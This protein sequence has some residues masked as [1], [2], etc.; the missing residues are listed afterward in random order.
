MSIVNE[1][2]YRTHGTKQ[3]YPTCNSY[4]YPLDIVQHWNR[5]YGTRGVLQ[6]QAVIPEA[7]AREGIVQL[8]EKLSSSRTLSF[9]AVLKSLG[10]RSDGLLS[11]PI[12]GKTLS[13]DLPY[14]GPE[15]DQTL[16]HLDEI[17]LRHGGRVYLAKD[18]CLA[19]ESFQEMY[20]KLAQFREIRAK[21]DPNQRFSSSQ[22]RRL[23]I[24]E[25]E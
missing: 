15:V 9:L 23:Q 12:H 24:L 17:V 14:T 3:F 1:T 8:L 7:T 11:F 18:S 21:L 22:A 4:F 5:G 2:F 20:P 6:Y 16:A 13:V 19:A 25:N 10:P